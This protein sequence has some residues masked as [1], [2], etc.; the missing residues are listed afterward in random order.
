MEVVLLLPSCCGWL[1]II[2][3]FSPSLRAFSSWGWEFLYHTVS[4][5]SALTACVWHLLSL[6]LICIEGWLWQSLSLNKGFIPP[7]GQVFFRRFCWLPSLNGG[8]SIN[9]RFIYLAKKDRHR[10]SWTSVILF[11]TLKSL[12]PAYFKITYMHYFFLHLLPL[13]MIFSCTYIITLQGNK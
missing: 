5:A 12:L 13:L 6:L 8:Q 11:Q 9:D 1:N 7:P 10:F 2:S 4:S 3:R